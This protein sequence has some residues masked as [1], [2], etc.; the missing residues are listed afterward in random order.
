MFDRLWLCMGVRALF[1]F[2]ACVVRPLGNSRLLP[3]WFH[4]AFDQNW[5]D[6]QRFLYV[7][8]LDS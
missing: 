8:P 7:V 4:R 5:L 2:L 6:F 1:P 3:Y